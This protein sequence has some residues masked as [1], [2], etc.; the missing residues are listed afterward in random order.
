MKTA[1]N[2]LKK[3]SKGFTLIELLIVVAI[4]GI[5]AAIAVPNFLNAR[6][7][8]QIGRV[9]AD[10]KAVKTA[11]EMYCIDHGAYPAYG[12]PNDYVTAISA[13]ALTYLP[14]RLTAPNA[15]INS[16]PLD[17][18][19]PKTMEGNVAINPVN[20]YKYIHSNDEIYRDQSF[21]GRHL[22]WHTEVTYGSERK[23]QYEIWSL[24]PDQMPGH[25]GLPYDVSNG[26]H[27]AGDIITHGP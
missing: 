22:R 15:Y 3:Q 11:I 9:Y 4:I 2:M 6:L 7:N 19:P 1:S 23:V 10:H 24:G 21:S 13:G 27:S 12:N 14:T 20:T 5:L 26:L 25:I 8:A 18:F 17:P 16:L